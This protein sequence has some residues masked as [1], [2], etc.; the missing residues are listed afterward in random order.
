[1]RTTHFDERYSAAVDPFS[2][3]ANDNSLRLGRLRRYLPEAME[4]LT[5]RQRQIVHLHF[6]ENLS[7]SQIARR[8]NVNPSSVS[9]CLS[10][11]QLRLQRVLRF[12]L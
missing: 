1:M 6:Y 7:V 3:E 11:A 2:S 8:L 5:A 12:I 10:R 9:R 4:D